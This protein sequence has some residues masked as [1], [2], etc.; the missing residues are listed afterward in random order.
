MLFANDIV[1][2]CHTKPELSRQVS[3][4]K[5]T[6]LEEKGFK[7]SRTK[8]EFL[9]F[10]GEEDLDDMKMDEEIIKRVQ[11]FQY[12]GTHVSDHICQPCSATRKRM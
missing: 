11:A 6:V 8:T 2:V 1:L 7:I 10:N 9:Q 12:Q 4:W 5:K 3:R